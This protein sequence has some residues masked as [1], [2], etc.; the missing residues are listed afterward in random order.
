MS[1]FG[2]TWG[3]S[4]CDPAEQVPV[5]VGRRC[6]WCAERFIPGERGI[7]TNVPMHLECSMRSFI[8]GANHIAG[9]CSCCGGDQDPDPPGLSKR[10]AA[11]LA[12]ERWQER[13]WSRV[14]RGLDGL[15][16]PG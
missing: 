16:G 9:T 6:F 13:E 10:E 4:V 2:P 1:W 5:P 7:L 3:A 14:L 8:G 12:Y 15:D 11:R